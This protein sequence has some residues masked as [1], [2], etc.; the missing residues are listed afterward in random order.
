MGPERAAG[1]PPGPPCR[2]DQAGHGSSTSSSS[3]LCVRVQ[4]KFKVVYGT[5]TF[6]NNNNWLRRKLLEGA[7]L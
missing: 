7:G 6:S 3:Q 5:P 2:L 1:T 4:A